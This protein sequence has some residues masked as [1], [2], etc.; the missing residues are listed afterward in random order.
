MSGKDLIIEPHEYNLDRVLANLDDIRR[1][2]KQRFEMEQLTAIVFE[3][4]DRLICVGYK[5]TSVDDYWVRGHMPEFPLLPGVLMC[6]SAAQL[7][8]YFSQK[9]DLLGAE[10]VGLGGLEDVRIRGMVRPGDRLVVAVQQLKIRRGAMI[11][12]RFQGLVD[13]V[14]V[15]EGIIKGVP[16]SGA[17][18]PASSATGTAHG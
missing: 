7:A 17:T 12:C 9:F 11:V 4:V 14:L 5:Q 18:S 8:S 15:C 10:T 1:L 6:E 2:N 13:D 16:L 3:D